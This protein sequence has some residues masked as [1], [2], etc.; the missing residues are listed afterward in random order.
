[1]IHF[2][3]QAFYSALF[4]SQYKLKFLLFLHEGFPI[5]REKSCYKLSDK[6]LS[7]TEAAQKKK[8]S[9][10]SHSPFMKIQQYTN[11]IF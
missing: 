6:V 7:V 8:K 9:N 10:S 3:K 2:I 11:F 5:L 4:Q 1:M